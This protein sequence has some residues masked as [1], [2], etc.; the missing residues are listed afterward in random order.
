MLNTDFVA[1]DMV[2]WSLFGISMAGY[3]VI[4]SLALGL[5]GLWAARAMG[6]TA[7]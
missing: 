1:C 5:V 6:R 4:A 3:N 2:P 7:P